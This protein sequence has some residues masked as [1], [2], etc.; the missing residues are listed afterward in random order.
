MAPEQGHTIVATQLYGWTQEI[1]F[2]GQP[3]F[4]ERIDQAFAAIKRAGFENVEGMLGWHE[5]R[6]FLEALD[7]HGGNRARAAA[8]LGIHKTTLWR[9]MRRYGITY[10]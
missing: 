6:R 10:P 7:R 3:P 1:N 8:W 2:P 9:K 5:D 4:L